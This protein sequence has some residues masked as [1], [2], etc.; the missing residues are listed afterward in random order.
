[1]SVNTLP[2]AV[3]NFVATTNAHDAEALF[4]VFADGAAVRDDGTTY[5][6]EAEIRDWIQVH[7]IGPQ[8][9]LTP[10]SFDNGRLVASADGDFDGGPIDFAFDFTTEGELVTELAISVA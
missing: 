2:A 5:A 10:T 7:Q 6:N 4:A 8:I 1:M 9:V 3:E